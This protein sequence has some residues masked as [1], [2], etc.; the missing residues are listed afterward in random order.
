MVGIDE[1]KNAMELMSQQTPPKIQKYKMYVSKHWYRLALK[2]AR[3]GSPDF[4]FNDKKLFFG[5][6]E[7]VTK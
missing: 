5:K 3:R 7:V 6:I 2:A 1:I 4:K